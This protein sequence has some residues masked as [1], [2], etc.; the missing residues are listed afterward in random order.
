LISDR[1]RSQNL[2]TLA[3][4]VLPGPQPQHVAL[5]V[6]GDAQGQVDGPVRDLALAD[7]HVDGI[8]E[9]DGVHGIERPALPFR[10]AFHDPVGDRGNSLLG[11][12][13]AVHLGQVRGDLP[14]GQPFRG[15]GN[16]HLIDAGQPPLP[17][18]DDF[19]LETGIA[20]PGHRNLHRSRVGKH[21]LGPPAVTGIAAVAAFR[22]VLAIPE[23]IVQ[24]AFQGALDDHLGQPAQQAAL[25]GQ[26]QPARPGPLGQLAQH[27]LVGRGEL[28]PGLVPV[29]CHVG[30]WCLL[31]SQELH[32]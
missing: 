23:V 29:L 11:Y 4:A 10:Q 26:L 25:T 8:D 18:G 17:F 14:V 13:S 2:A 15:K 21:R 5:A 1:T 20:V 3:V 30:H 6:H 9:H 28:G 16:D 22:V 7:L 24:L 12:L 31:P 32:H 27:L 19:R